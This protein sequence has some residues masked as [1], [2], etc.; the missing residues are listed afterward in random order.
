MSDITRRRFVLTGLALGVSA[1]AGASGCVDGGASPS[2]ASSS[3][4]AASPSTA[5]SSLASPGSATSSSAAS[6]SVVS[7]D[8]SA[9]G[10]ASPGAVPLNTGHA[11]PVIGLGTWTLSDAQAEEC[12]YAAIQSGMRLIDTASY[13]GTQAGVGRGVRRAIADGLVAREDVFVTTKL[14][15]WY[16]D[17][18]DAKI[19][20]C[21]DATGLGYIDLMLVHQRGSYEKQLYTAIERAVQAGTVRSPGLSNYYAP[22]E[23]DYMVDG[24]SILPAVIQNENHLFYQN[25]ALKERAAQ[26]GALVE[27]YYPMGGRG[28]VASHLANDVVGDIAAAHG[29]TSA[30]AMVRWHVQAGYIAI[31]GSG[32][33]DHIAENAQAFSFEL[34]EDE[35]DSIYALDRQERY[36]NW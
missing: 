5:S 35:M 30:Q 29:V 15:P 21:N 23:L 33:A 24:A 19:A 32:N 26:Y 3:D 13:Y 28:H 14:T 6:S 36:E 25:A 20:E 1:V 4:S 12:T 9:S 16:D 18:Y 31:P 17:D 11:M 27:S 8:S 22:E 34:S 10:G 7:S 2:V